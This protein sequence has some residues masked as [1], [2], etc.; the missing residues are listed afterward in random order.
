MSD[1][2]TWHPPRAVLELA[3]LVLTGVLPELPAPI[4]LPDEAAGAAEVVLEDAEGTPVAVYRPET[5]LL[6]ARKPFSHGPVRSERRT[7]AE[8][9]LEKPV[10]VAV[11]GS[12]TSATVEAA[13]ADAGDTPVLWLA[14]VG[15]GRRVDLPAAALLRA[16]RELPGAGAVVPVAVPVLADDG[17]LL[18]RVAAA[19]GAARLVVPDPHTQ[20]AGEPLHPAF[21]V[22]RER[23][24]PPPDRRGVTV[25][26]TGLS[27]SGKSTVAK[28]LVE[29]LEQVRTVSM[30]DGDEVRRLLSAGLGFGRADRD[31]NIRRIGFVAA[32]VTRHG[33]LAVC[34]P[35]APFAQTRAV[36]REWVE[37]NGDFVLIHVS[38]PL[39][40]CERRD[41]KGL[42]AKARAGE[43][44]EFTGISS[45]YEVPLDA[46]LRLDTSRMSVEDAVAAVYDLLLHRGYLG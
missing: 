5:G 8:V 13:L 39:A 2:V 24:L 30:L 27:G 18:E 21:V 11:S 35:I 38:T 29:R 25:F 40:E 9:G 14:L 31:L 46:D 1:T 4:E 19:Y 17:G 37:E 36:V 26:F 7:P 12:L 45:P 16:V 3:E 41:R 42:Y 6:E 22:E 33:G 20:L 23:T 34:A 28:R 10:A 43:I 44:P 15:A 32:E